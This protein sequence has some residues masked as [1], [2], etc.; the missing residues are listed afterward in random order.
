MNLT[1]VD[2]FF[3]TK[4]P[5]EKLTVEVRPMELGTPTGTPVDAF[6]QVVLSPDEINVSSDASVPTR[7][8][9]PSPIHLAPAR[10]YCIV[11][12][13]PTTNNYE[14]WV[15]RMGEKTVTSQTLPDAESVI[16]SKQYVGGSLFKSQNGTIWTPSQFEDLKF[17]LNKARFITEEPA[18]AFFYNPK[19][20]V[21]NAINQRLLPNAITTLPR[22]LK[23]GIVTTTHAQTQAKLGLGVKVSDQHHLQ[24]FKDL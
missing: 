6:S 11:L 1:S 13:A 20:D 14:A 18:T 23:V 2:L 9:F 10:E 22:K 7:V 15:A 8:T 24:Q 12:I 16:V 5:I 4:D 19:L 21:G 17:R 3:G